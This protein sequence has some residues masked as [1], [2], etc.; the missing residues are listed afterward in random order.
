MADSDDLGPGLRAFIIVMIIITVVSLALRF[1]SRNLTPS[2]ARVQFH[3][4][5]WDDWVALIAAAILLS[6]LAIEL[7]MIE[8]AGFGRH[9]ETLSL[10]EQKLFFKLLYVGDFI[11]DTALVLTKLSG[12]LFLSRIFPRHANSRLFNGALYATYGLNASWLIGAYFGT[13]F[14]CD[15]VEK[16]WDP[17]LEGECGLTTNLFLGSAIPSVVIDLIIMILPLPK[18]WGLR[19]TAGKKVGL[20]AI[21]ILGYCVIVVSLGRLITV[22][23]SGDGF[24][25]DTSYVAI[26]TFY[27]VSA[28][29]PV[30]IVCICLPA[31]LPL[32]NYIRRKYLDQFVTKI[33]SVVSAHSVS[34]TSTIRSKSGN[35]SYPREMYAETLHR[36]NQ[37]GL[38]YR[39]SPTDIDI[40]LQIH[41]L[42]D[43]SKQFSK[44]NI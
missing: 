16:G 7:V 24:N 17:F 36:E 35:F 22:L 40:E 41:P 30:T 43:R 38:S 34:H 14:L 12:L 25:T 39:D 21:F 19:T 37:N 10:E 8:D 29:S 1:W 5:W 31:M 20:I 42:P 28:E 32:G 23:T 2:A 9:M 18:I 6:Q 3:R 13:I 27:W 26:R 44:P 15:P 4:F 33:A 11:Y